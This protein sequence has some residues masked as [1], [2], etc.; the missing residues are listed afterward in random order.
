MQTGLLIE[1]KLKELTALGRAYYVLQSGN[2]GSGLIAL[3]LNA[4][5]GQCKILV[6]QR[7]YSEDKLIWVN[8]LAEDVVAEQD[9][10]AW[11]E[12]SKNRDPD[13]WVIE[14]E[15]RSMNNPFKDL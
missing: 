3:K 1:A 4:L 5:N 14:I 6:Q 2:Y 12:R 11:I 15:D 13:L 9:A 8:A 7:D 10:D